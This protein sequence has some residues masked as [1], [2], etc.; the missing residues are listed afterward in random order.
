MRFNARPRGQ[1]LGWHATV[2][3]LVDFPM[4]GKQ[5]PINLGVLPLAREGRQRHWLAL[6]VPP[7]CEES[8]QKLLELNQ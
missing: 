1:G 5:Y 3:E 2:Q 8:L 7:E 6:P 4:Q